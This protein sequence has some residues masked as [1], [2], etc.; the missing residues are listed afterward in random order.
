MAKNSSAF[1]APAPSA[2]A[3]FW[4]PS[5]APMIF[6][7]FITKNVAARAAASTFKIR[8]APPTLAAKSEIFW[9]MFRSEVRPRVP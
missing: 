4:N 3:S 8:S 6:F 9:M 1:P 7:T 5:T 2:F